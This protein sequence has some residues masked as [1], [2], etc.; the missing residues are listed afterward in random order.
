MYSVGSPICSASVKRSRDGISSRG[1]IRL[2]FHRIATRLTWTGQSIHREGLKMPDTRERRSVKSLLA[3]HLTLTISAL[4]SA[5][6]AAQ[7]S[8]TIRLGQV[9]SLSEPGR[10]D[11]PLQLARKIVVDK[12]NKK[13]GP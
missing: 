13:G 12:P 6:V 8:D 9:L 4:V 2:I 7:S 10:S 11:T 3:W 1:K 5:P